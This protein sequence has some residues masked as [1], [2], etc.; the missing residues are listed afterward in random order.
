MKTHKNII[1][2]LLLLLCTGIQAETRQ[3]T[4]QECRELASKAVTT[5]SQEE[6]KAAAEDNRKAAY[7][8]ALPKVS[9]NIGYHYT[10]MKTTLLPSSLNMGVGEVVMS[11]D[12]S[13]SFFWDEGSAI[14]QAIQ[15]TEQNGVIGE[16]MQAIANES[17]QMIADGYSQLYKALDVDVRNLFVA[18]VGITQP[19]YVGGRL[20]ELYQLSQLMEESVGLET[21]R[22]GAQAQLK[23]D[24][25]YWRVISVENKC[26]LADQYLELLQTL[27]GNVEKAVKRGMVT[28]SE[29]LKVKQKRGEAELKQLQA[30]NGL[31]LSKM[32]LCQVCG[33]PLDTEIECIGYDLSTPVLHDTVFDA[34]ASTE[35]RVELQ[36]LEN[37]QKVAES[38]ARILA[39]GLKPNIIASANYVYSNVSADNGVHNDF[40]GKG[41]VTAG[42]VVNIPIAHADDIYRVR[43][44]KHTAQAAKLKIEEA[45]HLFELQAQQAN[46]KLLEAQQK[47]AMC[48]LA[49]RNADEILR[50]A[51]KSYE[52]AM[53]TSSDVMQ[54]QTAWL[55]AATDLIDAQIEVQ[56]C[57]SYLKRYTSR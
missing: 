30:H 44:A 26:K 31:K 40:R 54:A 50:L 16:Q 29:L 48:E 32:A 12:G 28:K 9:A 37:A 21:E 3:L 5:G 33:L 25:A 41:F 8:A 2:L 52:A 6:L 4:L 20:K 19:I 7:A 43:A 27:E 46:N 51:T 11:S 13:S 23:A 45:H 57:E 47:V 53:V 24:E 36:L 35:G 55:S 42:V 39:A 1:I 56:V 15:S 34:H 49:M 38:N 14:G 22:E 17:G 18:Q 10:N